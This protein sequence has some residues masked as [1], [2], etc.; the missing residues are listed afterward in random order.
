M[1][2]DGDG[3]FPGLITAMLIGA[4]IGALV[5]VVGQAT[6]DVLANVWQHGFNMSEWQFSS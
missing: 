1:Y 6:T 3:H 5:G 4:E 2:S